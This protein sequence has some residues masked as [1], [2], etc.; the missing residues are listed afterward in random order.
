MYIVLTRDV[1]NPDTQDYIYS[2]GDIV[3]LDVM[4]LL[5]KTLGT[6]YFTGNLCMTLGVAKNIQTEVLAELGNPYAE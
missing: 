2:Y 1:I 5:Y 6:D 3:S 4:V